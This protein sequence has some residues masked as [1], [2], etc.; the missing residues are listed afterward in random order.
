MNANVIGIGCLAI[1]YILGILVSSI[2]QAR[3]KP[4]GIFRVNLTDPM[5][6]TFRLEISRPLEGIQNCKSLYFIVVNDATDESRE[7]QRL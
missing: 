4:D 3:K 7:K 1:G 5:K 2:M 6:D